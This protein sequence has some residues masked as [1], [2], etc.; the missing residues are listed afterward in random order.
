[1]AR[2][3]LGTDDV[4]VLEAAMILGGDRRMYGMEGVIDVDVPAE[5][6]IARLMARGMYENDA[7]ARQAK[8]IGRQVRL[9]QA[10]FVID[11]SGS[12]DTLEAQVDAAWRWIASIQDAVPHAPRR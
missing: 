1:R 8:Q 11:N 5:T 4:V 7:R 3:H 2:A 9:Q 12:L 10:D 6:A